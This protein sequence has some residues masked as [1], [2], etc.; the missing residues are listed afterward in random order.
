MSSYHHIKRERPHLLEDNESFSTFLRQK[1]DPQREW[2]Y[3]IDTSIMPQR[4]Y[5]S[6]PTLRPLDTSFSIAAP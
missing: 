3:H 4:D 6:P 5:T 2:Q 1:F